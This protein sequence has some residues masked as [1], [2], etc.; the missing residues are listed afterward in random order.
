ML[1]G[2]FSIIAF[3]PQNGDLGIAIASKALAIGAR[4]VF[5]VANLGAVVSQSMISSELGSNS[6]N[7]LNQGY[8]PNQVVSHLL[9]DDPYV[10]V[11]QIAVI[12][13]HGNTAAYTGPEA[14]SWA[15]DRQGHY[16]SIQGNMLVSEQVIENMASMFET[17][18]Q[19]NPN[20]ELAQHLMLALDA[21][22]KAGGDKRG[23]Q[24]AA[25]LVVRAGAGPNRSGGDRYIDLRVDDHISPID[26]LGR[27]LHLRLVSPW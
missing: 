23:K 13:N 10:N 15:G 19:N 20:F 16:Y 1:D 22:Q 18:R 14:R 2:T 9:Q 3:D 12:N 27:L 4:S 11:R 6:L 21:G 26:E 5:A 24:S 8:P 25:L 7:L 17:S